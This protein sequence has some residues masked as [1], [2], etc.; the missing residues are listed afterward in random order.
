MDN[1]DGTG[2][3]YTGGEIQD[4]IWF[5]TNDRPIPDDTVFNPGGQANSQEIVDFALN[6]INMDG[7]ADGGAEGFV[8]GEGDLVGVILAPALDAN[9][10][11][12]DTGELIPLE[13]QP[14]QPFIV[15]I[16]FED[17]EEAC[18]CVL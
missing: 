12:V 14:L 4:A 2:E 9:A 3:T 1:G 11:D 5:L 6:D 16:R 10:V 13:N 7:V 17:L 18:D 8:A 15:G